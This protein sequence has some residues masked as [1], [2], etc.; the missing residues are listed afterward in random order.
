MTL[1]LSSIRT[2]LTQATTLLVLGGCVV[3]PGIDVDLARRRGNDA[4]PTDYAALTS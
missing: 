4:S 3:G 1:P 2:I